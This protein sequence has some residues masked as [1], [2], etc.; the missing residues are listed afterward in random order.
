MCWSGCLAWR[1]C[2][3]LQ[4]S[5]FGVLCVL[6]RCPDH[7]RAALDRAI[8]QIIREVTRVFALQAVA[9]L[10]LSLL[11]FD[12]VL[13]THSSLRQLAMFLLSNRHVHPLAFSIAVRL[14]CIDVMEALVELDGLLYV[15]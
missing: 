14:R 13:Q 7:L 2:S 5:L 4:P 3:V 1:A 9:V 6:S 12:V 10:W 15:K 8:L 11:V